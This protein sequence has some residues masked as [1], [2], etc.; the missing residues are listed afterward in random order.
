MYKGFNDTLASWS[1]NRVMS[2]QCGQTWLQTFG[3]A[4]AM[5]N[6][7]NQLGAIQLVTWDDY[8]EGTEIE[9]GIDNCLSVSGS[10]AN[11]TLRW[12]VNGDES[13]VDHYT[14][15]ISLDGQ[16]LMSIG[17]FGVGTRQ[18]DL[19]SYTPAVGSTYTLYVKAVGKPSVR[20]Q[21]SGP[22][23]FSYS[24]GVHMTPSDGMTV[25]TPVAV[26]AYAASA[27]PISAMVAYV[28]YNEV[29]R[30]YSGS[31]STNVP[32]PAGNHLLVVN[33]WDSTGAL[34]QSKANITVAA[35]PPT[36]VLSLS[37]SNAAAPATITASTSAS[38][39]ANSGGAITSSTINWGDGA[40]SAGPT[41]S[42]SYASPGVYTVTATVSDNYG[43]SASAAS[44]L[45][46]DGVVISRPAQG[47]TVSS[48]VT[49]AATT[50]DSNAI[51]AMKVYVDNVAVFTSS[52]NTV[53]TSVRLKRG[54]HRIVI[55][56]WESGTG[57]LFQSAVTVYVQ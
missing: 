5:Y 4:N 36:A 40:S 9:S 20:N 23:T 44:T 19:R 25:A 49:I 10:M 12:A 26:N 35:M 28:D 48:P 22:V 15:F 2:Q 38:T 55:N 29:Y 18:V 21:M 51:A 53:N 3:K 14:V 33:A 45:T 6:S 7:S 47:A 42:H 56:A 1:G 11:T 41:A 16:N 13:T 57:V 39:D 54:T 27:N 37:S 52:S 31:L 17:D 32:L 50:V 8:E 24:A 46:V 43:M 30:T 34:M